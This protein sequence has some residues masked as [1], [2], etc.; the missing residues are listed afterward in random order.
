MVRKKRTRGESGA[1]PSRV[2][3]LAID[4]GGTGLKAS[5]LDPAGKMIADRV[6]VETPV[7]ASPKV[8]VETLVTLGK[9]LP[10]FDRVPGG[11]PGVVGARKLFTAPN[12]R[13]EA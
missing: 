6:R 2:H 5:V 12:L 8:I 3:T 4:V 13:H 7:G 11:F 10:T 1:G 9:P